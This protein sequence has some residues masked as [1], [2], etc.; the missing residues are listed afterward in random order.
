M[1]RADGAEWRQ[2]QESLQI[3][4]AGQLAVAASG[5]S[6]THRPL[7]PVPLSL[8]PADTAPVPHPCPCLHGSSSLSSKRKEGDHSPRKCSEGHQLAV[9]PE[10]GDRWPRRTPGIPGLQLRHSPPS[11]QAASCNSSKE[12][13]ECGGCWNMAVWRE[14]HSQR[15]RQANQLPELHRICRVAWGKRCEGLSLPPPQ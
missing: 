10:P 15:F 7:P 8:F 12:S 3:I 13:P 4:R 9:T 5:P 14:V 2:S 1:S 6:A 11:P